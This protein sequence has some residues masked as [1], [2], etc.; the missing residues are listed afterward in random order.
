MDDDVTRK[1]SNESIGPFTVTELTLGRVTMADRANDA[2]DCRDLLDA[3]GLDESAGPRTRLT[4]LDW[5][6]DL[7][8]TRSADAPTATAPVSDAVLRSRA[9]AKKRRREAAAVHLRAQGLTGHALR[10]A[11][12]RMEP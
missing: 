10:A 9:A 8:L 5:R 7:H 1:I 2:T 12:A 6:P 4:E 3:L 11:L